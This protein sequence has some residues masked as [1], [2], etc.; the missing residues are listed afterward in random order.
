MWRHIHPTIYSQA[1]WDS[2]RRQDAPP[3]PDAA[4]HCTG[5]K[6]KAE[7]AHQ[8]TNQALPTPKMACYATMA[9][10]RGARGRLF[11]PHSL[12]YFTS[13][14]GAAGLTV[15]VIVNQ[16]MCTYIP[17][18]IYIYIYIYAYMYVYVYVYIYIYIYVH[19]RIR[20]RI[21]L[22]VRLYIMKCV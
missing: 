6:G 17:V 7:V 4:P 13:A 19:I 8:A 15:D 12:N 3:I 21:R 1:P 16:Q 14:S 18:C 10:Q 11:T 20:I 2:G 22:Y 5:Q 9:V